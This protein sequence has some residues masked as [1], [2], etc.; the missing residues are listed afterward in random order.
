MTIA[1]EE[2]LRELGSK[3]EVEPFV[4]KPLGRAG[5]RRLFGRRMVA[6]GLAAAV[7]VGVIG[8]VVLGTGIR[9][10]EEETIA[11]SGRL[12]VYRD[13]GYG[14]EMRYPSNWHLQPIDECGGLS[15]CTRGALVSNV[16]RSFK[17][18]RDCD[19]ERDDCSTSEW[20]MTKVPSDFVGAQFAWGCCAMGFPRSDNPD[21][22][23]PLSLENFRSATSDPM[24]DGLKRMWRGIQVDGHRRFTV[25]VWTGPDASEE[26][27]RAVEAIVA[28][29]TKPVH[30]G[31][32]P[33]GIGEAGIEVGDQ[34]G[35]ARLR[36]EPAIVTDGG[37]QRLSVENTGSQDLFLTD[38]FMLAKRGPSGRW[39]NLEKE[40]EFTAPVLALSPGETTGETLSLADWIL[41]SEPSPGTYR[42]TKSFGVEGSDDGLT[43]RVLFLVVD[44]APRIEPSTEGKI[45]FVLGRPIGPGIQKN[46]SE[47]PA[48]YTMDA[49]GGNVKEIVANGNSWSLFPAAWSPDGTQ[50]MYRRGDSRFGAWDVVVSEEDGTNPRTIHHCTKLNCLWPG[51]W[52][53]DGQS[54]LFVDGLNV[55]VADKGFIE[56]RMLTNCDPEGDTVEDREPSDCYIIEGPPDWSPDGKRI[57]Y[58]PSDVAGNG[59]LVVMNADGSDPVT[60]DSCSEDVCL[61]GTRNSSPSWSPDGTMIAFAKM[62]N[63]YVVPVEGGDVIRVTDC[64]DAYR[65]QACTAER[66]QWS[67]DGRTI[68]FETEEGLFTIDLDGG[69]PQS[70]GPAGAYGAVWSSS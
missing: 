61:G 66:P 43:V 62:R 22:E 37:E 4:L 35:I 39:R 8:G 54:V 5:H 28:S 19:N 10:G 33:L 25:S 9:R 69:E 16:D 36:I 23:F 52:S 56:L 44:D 3:V 53:P 14:W 38:E 21:T 48:I 68:L 63:I 31:Q 64:P 49:D 6:F 13:P 17:H 58:T 46:P 27:I 34:Q 59:H 29:I 15:F 32:H 55:G 1:I 7:L 60:I 24:G 57:A 40:L 42:V 2:K 70:V 30:A 20:D 67:P 41:P 50:L 51:S 45:A 47:P 65:H 11:P 18:P 26:S 12:E